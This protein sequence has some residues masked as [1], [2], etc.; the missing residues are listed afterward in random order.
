MRQEEIDGY[1]AIQAS[2]NDVFLVTGAQRDEALDTAGNQ[3]AIVQ[4]RDS[5]GYVVALPGG[6]QVR[7][8]DQTTSKWEAGQSVTIETAN[9][10]SLIA[11][12]GGTK[13]A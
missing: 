3:V 10:R 7:V 2:Y 12:D 13:T 9:G 8:G 5:T 4:F 1:A 11:G 6:R